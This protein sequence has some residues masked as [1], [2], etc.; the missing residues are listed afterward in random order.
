MRRLSPGDEGAMAQWR[1]PACLAPQWRAA[2][3]GAQRRH[4]PRQRIGWRGPTRPPLAGRM[5][6]G[7]RRTRARV[8]KRGVRSHA[9]VSARARGGQAQHA[10]RT[11]SL[12]NCSSN[13]QSKYATRAASQCSCAATT[14]GHTCIATLSPPPPPS[15]SA[16]APSAPAAYAAPPAAASECP[17][18]AGDS[19]GGNGESAMESERR[20]RESASAAPCP[21]AACAAAAAAA[22]E[23]A[24][25][26]ATMAASTAAR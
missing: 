19:E 11:T 4:P 26:Q 25:A 9:S 10:A 22:S 5:P 23:V 20:R 24:L 14:M 16:A 1:A 21:G 8:S 2:C 6:A 3:A 15:S 7:R 17:R 13:S 18:T 12:S